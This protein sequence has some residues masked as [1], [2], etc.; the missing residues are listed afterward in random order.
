M[1]VIQEWGNLY[2]HVL[3]FPEAPAFDVTEKLKEVSSL[4]IPQVQTYRTDSLINKCISRPLDLM[5]DR[6]NL[7]SN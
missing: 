6:K 2:P 3:P 1:A 5:R 4:W 7:C